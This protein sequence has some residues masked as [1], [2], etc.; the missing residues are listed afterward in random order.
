MQ[1]TLE[2][3]MVNPDSIDHVVSSLIQTSLRGVDS[4]GINL[5]PHYCRAVDAK[6]INRTPSIIISQT[7]TSTAIVDADN[8]FGHHAG[9]VAMD[10]AVE[11]AKKTGVGTASVKNSTHFAAAAYFGFRA[12]DR[13]CLGFAFTNANALVKTFGAKEAFFGT[14]PICFTAPLEREGPFCLDMATAVVSWN[15]I[16]NYRRENRDIPMHWASDS[17]GNPVTDPG[18]VQTINP[19]GD[20][21]GY[22]LG[23]MIDILCGVL[24][25]GPASKDILPMYPPKLDSTKRRLSHFFMAIDIDKFLGVAQFK[26]N[27]QRIVD[28][29]R[30]VEPA[31]AG[32]KVMVAGDPEKKNYSIRVIEGIPVDDAIFEEF[33]AISSEFS[34]TVKS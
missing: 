4:H 23:M 19:V 17:K 32:Q 26:K 25:G 6:R 29:I 20:Y 12:A 21:K 34:R 13:D 18:Q 1:K 8:A 10:K 9:A 11:M 5:F 3:R 14:N 7:G 22:G 2:Q 33:L 28:E 16:N 27:L 24:A 15:K 30:V 31:V